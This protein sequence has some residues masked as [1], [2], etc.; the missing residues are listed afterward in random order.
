M[1]NLNMVEAINL[2][3]KQEMEKNKDIVLLGEDI[4]INGGVFRVTEGLYK[5]FPNRVVDTPISESGIIGMSIGMAIYGLK[6]V[7]EIQFEG[8][9]YPALDQLISHAA[10]FRNRTRNNMTASLVLRSPWGGGVKALEHHS[11]S[12]ET[13]FAHTPGL[14]VVIPSCPYDAKGLLISAIRD[15]NPVIFLEPKKLYRSIKQDVPE[16]EYAIPIGKANILSEGSDLTLITYGSFVR[17][18]IPIINSLP[19]SIELIDLR[20]LSPIDYETIINSV[21]KT[22]RAI[23]LHEAPRTLGIGAE[24]SALI[25]ENALLNLEAPVLRVTGYD[26]VTPA[27]K[28]ED[29]YRPDEAKIKRAIERVMNF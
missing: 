21:K 9:T 24:I 16:E 18:V 29:Y 23:I 4:G 5:K 13:Y 3:L 10:R 7:A 26:V 2:A 14:K 28:L 15:K 8:F 17:T 20:T 25:M 12:P 11:E 27:L 22:G 6:P 1:S 19:Y